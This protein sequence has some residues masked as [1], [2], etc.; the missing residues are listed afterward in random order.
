VAF[1]IHPRSE[2]SFYRLR[3]RSQPAVDLSGPAVPVRVRRT[4]GPRCPRPNHRLFCGETFTDREIAFCL[5]ADLTNHAALVAVG[6]AAKAE[7]IVG[8]AI[9]RGV[10]IHDFIAL[11]YNPPMMRA[12]R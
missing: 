4:T 1:Q 8:A 5:K 9:A 10:G 7:R 3:I 2:R 12:C 11:S 6:S